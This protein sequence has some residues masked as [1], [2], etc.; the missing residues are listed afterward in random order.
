MLNAD[1][2]IN[3]GRG[4][5]ATSNTSTAIVVTLD[6]GGT[7]DADSVVFVGLY[8]EGLTFATPSGWAVIGTPANGLSV[9]RRGPVEG[10]A[11]AESSWNFTPSATA[12]KAVTAG[13]IEVSA[14]DADT[15]VNVFGSV[16]QFTSGTGMTANIGQD[17]TLDGLLVAFHGHRDAG[18]ATPVTIGSHDARRNTS[19]VIA[20]NEMV[21]QGQAGTGNS[22]D[23]S[24]SVATVQQ[25]ASYHIDAQPSRTPLTATAPGVGFAFVVNAD[26]AKQYADMFAIDGAE[27]GVITGNAGGVSPYRFHASA[28]AGV[29][30]S[31]AAARSGGY[32]WAFDSTSAICERVLDTLSVDIAGTKP[33]YRRCFDLRGDLTARRLW[34]VRM[35]TAAAATNTAI[36]SLDATG[37]ISVSLNGGGTQL[38]DQVVP[39][40][41]WF[42]VEFEHD[43]SGHVAGV[44]SNYYVNWA[45]DYDASLTD[46][47][48]A[49]PQT[50]VTRTATLSGGFATFG[51][52][53]GWGTAI[54]SAMYSDDGVAAVTGYPLGDVRILPLK[55]DPAGTI[56][57]TTS[58]NF[59]VMTGNGTV[60][61][62]NATNARNAIDDVPPNLAGT[63]D[64]L[65][66]LLASTTDHAKIP[67]ETYDLAAN[68]VAV[69]G[70]K[71]VLCMWAASA[72]TSTCRV[73]IYDG[74]TERTVYAEADPNADNTATPIWLSG[75]LRD[76][77]TPIVWTQPIVN[78]LE[79]WF[80]SNDPNPDIGPDCV[81]GEL[82]VVKALPE[83]LFGQV[84]EPIY[85]EA[86]RDP[87]TQALVG[88]AVTNN[89][90]EAVE[91]VWEVDGVADSSGSIPDG[92][93]DQYVPLSA[94]GGIETVGTISV[95][96][97]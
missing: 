73:K 83:N 20:C 13:A 44:S 64:A 47:T 67:L 69:R 37:K 90:G 87:N 19:T 86:H 1:N 80:G 77:T 33:V 72:T 59:G 18:N 78:A 31:A 49:V 74:T 93:V 43:C 60:A 10:L 7:T 45:V 91:L 16:V 2:L 9:Y 89:S 94:D 12:G 8:G 95:I 50:Q 36:V 66:A 26:G 92:T 11:A 25:V 6:S 76:T 61:A 5:A 22:V 52:W 85:A 54:T 96:P 28:S 14:L 56:T 57:V 65:V 58:T 81:V 35:T 23:L 40:A 27:H 71:W 17:S 53:V 51:E 4:S 48:P 29:T 84:D 82:V 97:G 46:T 3:I 70:F 32:G 42:A 39:T 68:K 62:W 75:V 30:L 88:A 34:Q 38:S 55:V 15:T 21:E 63:R 24:V 41:G 79:V